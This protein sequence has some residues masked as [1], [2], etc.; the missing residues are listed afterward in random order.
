[1]KRLFSIISLL[2]IT[3]SAFAQAD[4]IIGTWLSADKK[5]HVEIYK[6]TSGAYYGKIIWL[7]EPNDPATG[8]PKVDAKNPD[9]SKR[10]NPLIGTLTFINFTYKDGEYTGGKIY[11]CRDGKTYTGKLWLNTDGTLSMRGYIGFLYSTETWTRIK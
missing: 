6:T 10:S 5:A 9:A 1:M 11:D 3:T 7:A 2:L 4:K 8:K